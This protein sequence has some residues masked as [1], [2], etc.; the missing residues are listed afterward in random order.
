MVV[1][2]VSCCVELTMLFAVVEL[3]VP[4]MA[5]LVVSFARAP[6]DAP[7]E[8]DV[9]LDADG[10]LV[11]VVPA[12]APWLLVG[13][14]VEDVEG[15]V[16]EGEEMLEDVEL[17]PDCDEAVLELVLPDAVDDDGSVAALLA[18]VPL[19]VLRSEGALVSGEAT[20]DE[21]DDEGLGSVDG[22]VVELDCALRASVA[23]SNAAAPETSFTEIIFIWM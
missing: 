21:E 2:C 13:S 6:V 1:I 7:V 8:I 16:D 12:V 23:A 4:L 20:L 10:V 17:L 9:L 15:A 14:V 5:P 3:L 19:G 11:E 22:R 18:A